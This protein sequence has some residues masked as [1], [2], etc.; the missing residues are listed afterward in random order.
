MYKGRNRSARYDKARYEE[1]KLFKKIIDQFDEAVEKLGIPKEWYPKGAVI[2]LPNYQK[3]SKVKMV[4]YDEDMRQMCSAKR[5]N[6][7]PDDP[8]Y[9]ASKVIYQNGRCKFH[10]GCMPRG[11]AS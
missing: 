3:Y 8:L 5:S 1:R 2:A 4:F 7:E 9:C 6:W 11:G 10:G